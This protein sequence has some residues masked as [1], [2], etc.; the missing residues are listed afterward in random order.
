[1]HV[2]NGQIAFGRMIYNPGKNRNKAPKMYYWG[3]TE[4][5]KAAFGRISPV[6]QA[7]RT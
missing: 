5:G 3:S 2:S 6:W 1:M 7:S 4:K